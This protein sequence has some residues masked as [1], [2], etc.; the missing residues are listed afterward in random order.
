MY[1]CKS[2][3]LIT[4]CSLQH[5]TLKQEHTEAIASQLREQITQELDLQKKLLPQLTESLTAAVNT[6]T[7]TFMRKW[8]FAVNL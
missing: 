5:R 1:T 4:L 8:E 6:S 2:Y 7:Q 3:C